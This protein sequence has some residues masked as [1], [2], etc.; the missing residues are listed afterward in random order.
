MHPAAP[1]VVRE[2][3]GGRMGWDKIIK[4]GKRGEVIEGGNSD[5][6]VDDEGALPG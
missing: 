3:R 1:L 2:K 5:G 6:C 4:V